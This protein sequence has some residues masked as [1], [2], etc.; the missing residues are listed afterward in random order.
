[1]TKPLKEYSAG[2]CKATI[3]Q[4][5]IEK[6][7]NTFGVHTI[8]LARRYKDKDGNWKETSNYNKKDLADIVV[9]SMQALQFLSL[10]TNEKIAPRQE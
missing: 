3:W 10:K 9:L 4:N 7:G 2:A 6:N 1:M 8:K 5:E